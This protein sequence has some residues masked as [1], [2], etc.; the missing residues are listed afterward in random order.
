M[1]VNARFRSRTRT[2]SFAAIK[3]LSKLK[4]VLQQVTLR[5]QYYH[6]ELIRPIFETRREKT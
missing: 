4:F 3:K 1:S 2:A 6:N 5:C